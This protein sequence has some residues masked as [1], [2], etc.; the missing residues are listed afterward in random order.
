M[1]DNNCIISSKPEVIKLNFSCNLFL[2]I[3]IKYV[4]AK[5]SS[6]TIKWNKLFCTIWSIDIYI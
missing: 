1:E 4:N 3:G 6:N 5:Q 2:K